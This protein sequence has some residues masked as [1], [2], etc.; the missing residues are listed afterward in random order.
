MAD[1][2][3]KLRITERQAGDVT[4]LTL[5]GEITLDDGDLAFGRKIDD[6][7]LKQ[8]RLK[9]LVDLGGV[10]YIDSSGIGMMAAELRNI[11]PK[12]GIFKLLHLK[13]RTQRLLGM[14][15]LMTVFETFDDEALAIRSFSTQ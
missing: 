8:G 1:G 14:M 12:G 10:T 13:G 15:K 9:I 5:D 11:H 6:L 3:S 7:V 2:T 4:I